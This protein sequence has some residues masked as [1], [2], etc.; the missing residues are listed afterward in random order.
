MNGV[1]KSMKKRLSMNLVNPLTQRQSRSGTV[2]RNVGAQIA[3]DLGWMGR[4]LASN[5][6]TWVAIATKSGA[7]SATR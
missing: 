2:R 7:L 5:A 6:T 3:V 4:E 1:K